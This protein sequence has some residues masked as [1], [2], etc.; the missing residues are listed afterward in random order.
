MRRKIRLLLGL[1]LT[2]CLAFMEVANASPK[3]LGDTTIHIQEVQVEAF[4]L[5]QP[6]RTI[7]GSVSLVNTDDLQQGDGSHLYNVLNALPGV[8]MQSGTYATNR[9][10]IRGMG[11]RTPYN[12]NRIRTYL[13]DIPLTSSDGSSSPEELDLQ[14]LSRIEIIKGPASAIYGSGLGGTI[15]MHTGT[16]PRLGWNAKT[17]YGSFNTIH[18]A[19]NGQVRFKNG[20]IGT[21]VGHLQTEGYRQNNA[22]RRTNILATSNWKFN[23]TQVATTLL[24]SDALGGIPSSIGKT[25]YESS[26]QSAAPN[27]LAIEGYKA[28]RKAVGGISVTQPVGLKGS[29]RLTVFGRWN[30][31]F[32]KRPFN[33]LDDQAAALGIRNRLNFHTAQTDWILG[34]ELITERYS[35][36]LEKNAVQINKNRENRQQINAFG[37]V[38][39]RLD[40]RWLLTAAGA[41]NAVSYRLTDAFLANGDQSGQRT[42]P[43]QFSPRIGFNYERN[44]HISFYGSA[45]HGFSLPSPEETLLPAGDVNPDIQPEKGIQVELGT[46]ISAWQNRL[47]ID[48]VL[49][50]IELKDLLVTKRITEDIFTGINA[51][52]TRHQGLEM[53]VQ[54]VWM[55]RNT[56]PGSFKSTVS[57]NWNRHRFID[58]TDDGNTYNNKYLPGIPNQT[59][60]I[61]VQWNPVQQ[62]TWELQTRYS[63]AQFIND[64]NTEK[65]NGYALTNS[66]LQFKSKQVKRPIQLEIGVNNLFDI[67][68]ASML[69]VNAIAIGSNEPRYYYPGLPRHFYLAL[70]LQL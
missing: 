5:N 18:A 66:K 67:H 6:L 52:R 28:S 2:G 56:F 30:D 61:Q 16:A 12:T 48:A 25:L 68:Y 36:M 65:M 44:A 35:W 47:Y 3:I 58:F 29:N 19:V 37:M 39:H 26:P 24:L 42:F 14:S 57:Y 17:Q 63:G 59:A 62:V 70:R 33:N 43:I 7:P 21:S 54:T 10:V 34:T 38:Y 27:W 51:G 4:Q 50:Q 20:S 15:N 22:Y 55:N 45:G 32:E 41:V 49:Y 46:R 40:E 1:S 69:V 8:S 9:I 60:T 11:S 64:S 31:N 13:N 23:Q 53:Q